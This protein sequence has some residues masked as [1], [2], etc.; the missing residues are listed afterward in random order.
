MTKKEKIWIGV[1]VLLFVLDAAHMVLV[2]NWLALMW[3]V[4]AAYLF[5][6]VIDLVKE[7]MDRDEHI[8]F[9]TENNTTRRLRQS[10]REARISADNCYRYI[11]TIKLLKEENERLKILNKN[12]IENK[13]TG[14][15][16]YAR[17]RK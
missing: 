1:A 5:Y 10:M 17:K 13:N 12:L 14:V 8:R 7:C 3:V 9:L 4:E 2:R 11:N 6:L 16:N 15:K